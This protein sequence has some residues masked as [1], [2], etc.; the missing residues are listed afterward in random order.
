[1]HGPVSVSSVLLSVPV[2]IPSE[3]VSADGSELSVS[4]GNFVSSPIIVGSL[5]GKDVSSAAVEFSIGSL[6]G[7]SV[8]SII[9]SSESSCSVVSS[10]GGLDSS[11]IA[12]DSVG[13]G[14]SCIPID[15]DGRPHQSSK[16]LV[17]VSSQ[18]VVPN[19]SSWPSRTAVL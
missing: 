13:P 1:M 8:G 6:A 11:C 18:S 15:R 17:C 16:S 2:G 3:L 9:G 10:S 7:A 14:S 19:Q 5:V 12:I 4:V